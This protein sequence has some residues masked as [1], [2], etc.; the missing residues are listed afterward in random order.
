MYEKI[1]S[2]NIK[3]IITDTDLDGVV[4]GAILK[5]YWKEAEV[6]FTQP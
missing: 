4:T 2:L 5:R 3:R 6:I 1:L